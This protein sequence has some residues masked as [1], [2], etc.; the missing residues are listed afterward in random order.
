ML[1][2][3]RVI[4]VLSVCVMMFTVVQP[5][6]AFV[7]SGKVETPDEADSM[8]ACRG[9]APT[10]PSLRVIIPIFSA[11]ARML[12]GGENEQEKVADE[13]GLPET[14]MYTFLDTMV[15]WLW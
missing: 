14:I 10:A 7:W 13:T 8:L 12:Y 2:R 5:A 6:C 3:S 9:F 11:V 1:K 4:A 15:T